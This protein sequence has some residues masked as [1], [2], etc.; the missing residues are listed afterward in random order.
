MANARRIAKDGWSNVKQEDR[1]AVRRSMIA[2]TAVLLIGG[3]GLWILSSKPKRRIQANLTCTELHIPIPLVTVIFYGTTKLMLWEFEGTAERADRDSIKPEPHLVPSQRTVTLQ[4]VNT[5]LDNKTLEITPEPTGQ[6]VNIYSPAGTKLSIEGD[7]VSGS[8]N[9]AIEAPILLKLESERG[10]SLNLTWQVDNP[11]ELKKNGLDIKPLGFPPEEQ[12]TL[13]MSPFPDSAIDFAFKAESPNA[14]ILVTFQRRPGALRFDLKNSTGS[15]NLQATGCSAGSLR[16][17]ESFILPLSEMTEEVQ[18]NSVALK[19]IT[20]HVADFNKPKFGLKLSG[21]ADK[22]LVG[23]EDKNPTRLEEVL[24]AGFA[25][26]T[27]FGILVLGVI[28]LL[29]RFANRAL[30]VL[31][32]IVIPDPKK[33]VPPTQAPGTNTDH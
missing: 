26:Q 13:K 10:G 1:R 28:L 27:V 29:G 30:E 23:R 21:D 11:I 17:G 19:D 2:L 7:D 5:E 22:V 32:S 33:T 8:Q 16:F 31:S 4:F 15:F 14:K 3:V 9:A 25:K 6:L 12:I 18:F 20:L 24:S